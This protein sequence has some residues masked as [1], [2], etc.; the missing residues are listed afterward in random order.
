MRV[1][2]VSIGILTLLLAVPV[3]IAGGVAWWT[4]QHRSPDGAFHATLAP[5]EAPSRIV[6]VPDVDALLRRDAPIARADETTLRIATDGF[7]GVGE[8]GDVAAFL[9]GSAYT[10]LSGVTLGRGWLSLNTKHFYGT[11]T[12]TPDPVER[13]FWLRRGFGKLSWQ[14]AL[15]RDRQLTL[16]IVAPPG[17][18]A[19]P[20]GFSPE[21]VHLT[22]AVTA[23]W[24]N[25][26]AWGLL[27]L[28]PVLL[29]LGLAALAWPQRP[30]EIVYVMDSAAAVQ[31]G[32]PIPAQLPPVNVAYQPIRPY[33]A[34][35]QSNPPPAELPSELSWP[36]AE[37]AEATPPANDVHVPDG[38]PMPV[39][40][41][42]LHI[43]QRTASA[44]SVDEREADR[45]G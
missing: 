6:V 24:L 33:T 23:G 11:G 39:A 43:A 7:I 13:D 18:S 27:I 31:A 36:P 42:H 19:A 34:P 2:R 16:V 25:T 12:A 35:V 32:L 1:L 15:D 17:P 26:T 40:G 4:M 21:P 10:E 45:S 20:S 41:M 3:L 38:R 9:A 44:A 29:L 37:P 28:G 14:P 5:I 8:P 30:R 22:A